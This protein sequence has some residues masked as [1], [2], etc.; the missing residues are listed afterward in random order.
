MLDTGD[1]MRPVSFGR[2]A[3]MNDV[4]DLSVRA[5]GWRRGTSLAPVPPNSG[6]SIA[7]GRIPTI[8]KAPY[9]FSNR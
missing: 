7:R 2:S 1:G 4:F 5:R 6:R 8:P 9:I 3:G